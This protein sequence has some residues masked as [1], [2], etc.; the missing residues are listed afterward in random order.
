MSNDAI[1]G[2]TPG[3]QKT[4]PPDMNL[5]TLLNWVMESFSRVEDKVDKF[6]DK[7]DNVDKAVRD[8]KT[9]DQAIKEYKADQENRRD[10]LYKTIRTVSVIVGV[11]IGVV[12]LIVK[13]L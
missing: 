2:T 8:I 3:N 5:T 6:A 1:N 7:V 11:V 12:T 13:L 9:A 10:F 4:P